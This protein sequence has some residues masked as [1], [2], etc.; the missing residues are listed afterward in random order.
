MEFR[1]QVIPC[2]NDLDMGDR[3][4]VDIPAIWHVQ[5]KKRGA[6]IS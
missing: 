5:K 2:L 4:V 1:A 6:S 3:R